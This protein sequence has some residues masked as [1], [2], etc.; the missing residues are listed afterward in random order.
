MEDIKFKL[1]ITE[2]QIGQLIHYS[3]TDKQVKINTSDAIRFA[4][5]QT[6]NKWRKIPRRIYTL[7]NKSGDLL[8]IIWLR[9]QALPPDKDYYINFDKEFFGT[10]FAIRI[11]GNARGKGPAKDFI[12]KAFKEYKKTKQ[13]LGNTKKS[14]WLETRKDN[15]A[16]IKLYE[17]F[18]FKTVSDPDESNRIIMIQP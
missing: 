7:T 11:Y 4:N 12:N 8:G 13:Y 16:A 10:T 5:R 9:K 1:G 3:N 6:F 18:G 14:M 15:L 2:K 17:K